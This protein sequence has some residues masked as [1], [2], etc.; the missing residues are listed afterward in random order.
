MLGVPKA[1]SACSTKYAPM[2]CLNMA[3]DSG[4]CTAAISFIRFAVKSSA[5]PQ[6]TDFHSSRPRSPTRSSGVRSRSGSSQ[7]PMP[8]VPRVHS[9]P[10]ESGS[11]GLPSTFQSLPS[12][13]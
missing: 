4:P 7:A 5:S 12:R 9:R 10:R 13:T 11:S 8:P 1:L 6:V 3:I 2:P